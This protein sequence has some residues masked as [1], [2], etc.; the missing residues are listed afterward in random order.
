MI[1]DAIPVLQAVVADHLQANG[2]SG[3]VELDG[4]IS[5]ATPWRPHI[6][7]ADT[8]TA[9][10]LHSVPPDSSSW[11]KRIERAL[12]INPKLKI[13]VAAPADAFRDVEF[14]MACYR[15]RAQLL[16][17]KERKG[18][19]SIESAYGSVP[20]LVCERR[21]RFDIGTAQAILDLAREHALAAKTNLEKGVTLELLIALMLS[22]VD[23][24]EVADIG[25]ANRTQQ[26][27]V[28]VHNRS[29]GGIL[30]NSSIVLAEAKNWRNKKVTPT[31]HA[32]FLR[33]LTSRNRRAKLGFLVTTGS[34]T[35]GLALEA[36]RDSTNDVIVVFIDGKTL[37][38]IWCGPQT[39]TQRIER[40][41]IEAS[42]GS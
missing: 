42:V 29:V 25:I 33:K 15:L 41:V 19:F 24:F 18:G 35:A 36:R 10:Q 22:Q 2:V 6:F 13:G 37:P 20:D 34:F 21:T 14:L 8:N 31:E 17:L 28:L 40:L 26:M 7:V 32:L 38:K 39:I 30:S 9:W 23:N 12:A 16:L 11:E 27:D 4:V 5:V 3:K 1:A